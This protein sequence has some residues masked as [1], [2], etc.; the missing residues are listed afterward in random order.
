MFP[1]GEASKFLHD[2]CARLETRHSKLYFVGVDIVEHKV[3]QLPNLVEFYRELAR[4]QEKALSR[5]SVES[6]AEDASSER[7]SQGIPLLLFKDLSLDWVR[8]RDLFQEVASLVA[9]DSSDPSKEIESLRDT[10]AS[11]PLLEHLVRVWYEGS[12][13][14]PIAAERGID[15]AVLTFVVRATINPFLSAYCKMLSPLIDQESWRRRY[16]PV[17]GGKPDFAYLDKERRA[18]WLL[19]SRCDAQWLFLRLECPYCGSQNQDALAYFTDDQE[20]Y[21]Y[22]LYVCEQCRTY[23]KAIDLRR[24]ESEIW[25]PFER[26]LT[27]DM[28]KQGLEKGYKPG[29]T[30]VV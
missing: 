8:V 12:S 7:L 27:L 10:A 29:W 9:K 30:T 16:C 25:L 2:F 23:I 24:T 13:L 18:R 15:E 26:I 4:I 5:F 17:C 1:L 21:L 11:I 3:S 19:C 14:A 22:R 28:D 20:S 6:F